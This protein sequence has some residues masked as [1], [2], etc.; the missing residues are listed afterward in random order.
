M[1]KLYKVNL[2]VRLVVLAST[3][4]EALE[5]AKRDGIGE[6]ET[7]AGYTTELNGDSL[8]TLNLLRSI[9]YGSENN[10]TVARILEESG[11][12]DGDGMG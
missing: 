11:A 10:R 5:I 9:P 1:K 2:D 3:S 12:L 4:A 6:W 7:T 8:V